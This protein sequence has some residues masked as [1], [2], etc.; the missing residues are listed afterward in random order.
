MLQGSRDTLVPCRV[1]VDLLTRER[2]VV[3][4]S[5]RALTT[6]CMR[7][8]VIVFA[9]DLLFPPLHDLWSC[10]TSLQ[11]NCTIKYD[12]TFFKLSE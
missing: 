10:I 11:I 5:L 6:R 7:N 2:I 4:P 1:V 12:H 8:N 9:S 3:Q